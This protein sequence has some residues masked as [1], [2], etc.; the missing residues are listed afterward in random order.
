M[1]WLIYLLKVTACTVLFF[2]FYVVVL[3]KLTFFKINRFYLLATLLLSFVIPALQFEVKREITVVETEIQAN[4][5]ELKPVSMAPAQLIQPVMLEYDQKAVAKID[6]PVLISYA[7]I[8]IASLLLLVCLWQLFSLLRHTKGYIKNNEGLKLV[9]KTKGFTNCSFFSYV[10]IDADQ[11]SDVDFAVLLKHEQVHARQYHS[12]DKIILMIFKSLLWFNPIVYLYDKALEQV[13]EYEADEITSAGFGNQAYASLLL[14]LAVSKT[15]IPLIHNFVK[16]PVKDRIKMLFHTK[17]KHMKKLIYILVLPIVLSLVYSF[18]VNYV[19]V[20]PNVQTD[21]KTLQTDSLLGKSIEGVVIGF[22]KKKS[23]KTFSLK[24]ASGIYAIEYNNANH[25]LK[26]GDKVVVLISG[27]A[28]PPAPIGDPDRFKNIDQ[29]T[30]LPGMIK[31]LN[32]NLIYAYKPKKYPFLYEVNKARFAT[33]KIKS[34]QKDINNKIEKIVLNDGLFS[35][36]LNLKAQNIQ[37]NQFKVG[38]TVLVKF[39]GERLVSK[40]NY[41]TDKMIVLYS[42]PRKYI[43]KN[44]ALYNRFYFSDG[45]QKVEVKNQLPKATGPV[46]PKIISFS[47]IT[48]DVKSKTSYLENAIVEVLNSRL[49]A[50][51]VEIDEANNK[52]VAKNAS[53]TNSKDNYRLESNLITFNLKKGGFSF[54]SGNGEMKTFNDLDE[55][56]SSI[57]RKDYNDDVKVQYSA[58][59]SVKMSRDKSVVSLFGNA[60]MIYKDVV[61]SGDKIVY[62]KHNNSVMVHTATMSGENKVIKADS[63]FF[64]LRTEKAKLYGAGFNR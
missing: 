34:I 40:N 24:T 32:G 22:S 3:R 39:I 42:E 29:I 38:D 56:I 10:F 48:G 26:I 45:K 28:L 52:M 31:H 49:A 23:I 44:E 62:N 30:Y 13:H 5:P 57:S 21:I 8:G 41:T 55:L 33:S 54:D 15:D 17:S 61:L 14:K 1:E 51:Y 47:K 36:S 20:N 18:T 11:L 35:I 58:Q 59:D 64:N 46:K 12:V 25:K 63:L 43:I 37:D 50:K 19:D 27:S 2:G 4:V 6:W 9:P 7:Y 53:F 60:K 16:S